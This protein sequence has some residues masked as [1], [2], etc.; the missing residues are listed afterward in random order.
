MKKTLTALL[1][2]LFCS[3]LCWSVPVAAQSPKTLPLVAPEY[4]ETALQWTHSITTPEDVARAHARQVEIAQGAKQPGQSLT[5]PAQGDQPAV[6]LHLYRPQK[7]AGSTGR[8]LPAI[9]FLHGG[10]YLFGTPQ[11]FG[12]LMAELA[13][14]HQAVVVALQYRLAPQAP[15]PAALNDAYH[16]LRYLCRNPQIFGIDAR[17]VILMGESA[18]GGLAA[19]LALFAR[20][21]GEFQPL[22]QV[23]TYP[24]LDHRTGTEAS[25]YRAAQHTGEFV[26][27]P[28]SN[29]YAWETLRGGKAIDAEQMPYFSPALA[30][31]LHGLPPA[32]IAVGDLDLFV[33][34]NVDYANRLMQAGVPTELHVIPGVF[35]AF[36]QFKPDT[37]QARQF[38]ALRDAAIARMLKQEPMP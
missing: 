4:H 23:L 38:F 12:N 35:H 9:Y 27:T 11:T 5:A 15:F 36:Q 16:G 31:K 20:D 17:K 7:S 1:G 3:A 2:A 25:P 32:F 10:G 18:G 13:E 24:M 26:W 14:R 21:Q 22:G 6:R 8:A 19:R 30:D 33:N 34:E 29:R 37:P 28:A